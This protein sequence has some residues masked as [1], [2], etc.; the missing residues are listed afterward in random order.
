MSNP[1]TPR[2][3]IISK[4]THNITST[5]MIDMIIKRI[6]ENAS[7]TNKKIDSI[8]E[9]LHKFEDRMNDIELKI[10]QLINA[11]DNID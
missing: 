2:G 8:F 4:P 10:M 5:D 9:L 11:N 3:S 1:S 6:N 7:K